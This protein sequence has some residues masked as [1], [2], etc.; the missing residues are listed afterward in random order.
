MG[1]NR[2]CHHFSLGKLSPLFFRPTWRMAACSP[3][4]RCQRKR[5]GT[6]QAS[7]LARSYFCTNRVAIF[8]RENQ[9][10]LGSQVNLNIHN[11]GYHYVGFLRIYS[12]N[13]PQHSLVG[14]IFVPI[15]SFH[16]TD[17]KLQT[18]ASLYVRLWDQNP[19]YDTSGIDDRR[20]FAFDLF[21]SAFSSLPRLCNRSKW[22]FEVTS[23]RGMTD[24][25]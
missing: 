6:S 15:C 2:C 9:K 14:H 4:R 20:F 7:L 3:N 21:P 5:L 24:K 17:D 13:R 25:N 23:R 10:F 8:S 12:F 19:D 16:R 18:F 11:A 1:D 22:Y